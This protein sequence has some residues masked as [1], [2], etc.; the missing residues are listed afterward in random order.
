[1]R[2][3][4]GQQALGAGTFYGAVQS[5][6][7]QCGAIFSDLCHVTPRKLPSHSHELAFFAL[8]MQGE[9]GERYG[10]EERQFRP[11]TMHFRPAGVPHQDEIGPRGVKFFEIEIR[12]QWIASLQ[13][14]SATL[15]TP[16]DDCHGGE[17]VWLGMKLFRELHGG[18][19]DDLSVESLL[20]EL[21]AAAGRASR[22]QMKDAPAWLDRIR[23]KL[24]SDFNERLTLDELSREAGVHPVHL[25]R[26]FRR[27]VGEGIGEHVHRLRVRAACEE[28]LN[29]ET[30]LSEISL[31]AGF[32]DQSHFTRVFRRITGMTPAIFRSQMTG[33]KSQDLH[34]RLSLIMPRAISS[35]LPVSS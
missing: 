9:Y 1:M 27:F 30:P 17:L 10:R 34:R 11:F 33:H 22:S 14:C 5:R 6:R 2:Q 18:S 32:A 25:S 16:R 3:R 13:M 19:G 35:S 31:G 26:V 12:Q 8:L 4:N 21:V 23:Q 24:G 20:A 15:N 7:E 29:P 28:M